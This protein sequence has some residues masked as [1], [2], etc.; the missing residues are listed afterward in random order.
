MI[1][2]P[3]DSHVTY[4]TDGTPVYDRAV[5]SAPL[6]KL[7]KN[8][9]SDGVLPN[10]S[11]N[12]Q[13][14]A[15]TGMNVIVYP[16]FAC[17]NGCM[18]L[19]ESQRTLAVQAS[20]TAYDRID[21]VVLRL[22]DNDSERICDFYILEGTPA[23]SP[24][25]PTLTRSESVWELGLADLFIAK[26]STA[27]S[28]QRI[29]DTRYETARC[30]IMS[31]VSQF[32]T[33]TLYNQIQADLENFQNVSQADFTDWF[34]DIKGQ[35]S[36]DPAGNLQNQIGNLNNLGTA[37]KENI[38]AAVNEV[39]E[40]LN[41]ELDNKQDMVTGAATTVLS[42]N[43]AVNRALAANEIGKIVAVQTTLAELLCLSGVTSNIQNQLNS[44]I[45]VF[46]GTFSGAVNF[47]SGVWNA[48]G[49]DVLFGDQN[50]AGGFCIK[51]A[52]GE[53]S[54]VLQNQ[55]STWYNRI[56]SGNGNDLFLAVNGQ[57]Y[58]S[59]G[60][61][62]AR[63]AIHASAFIQSSSRRLKENIEDMS[64]EEAKK[65]L[66][67]EPVTYDYINEKEGT[68][69]RGLIAEDTAVVIPSCVVGDVNCADDDK[70]ALQ[71]IGI[72]YSKLVPY[73]IKMIQMQQKD[74]ETLKKSLQLLSS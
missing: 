24:V 61:N 12:M 66:L 45:S 33:T 50:I 23:T 28:N 2:F 11:T 73:L 47:A 20:N 16:G 17:C 25:R 29:T 9:F 55:N 70:A 49:D 6:R 7:I 64:E 42:E 32:D 34:E 18:K 59:N 58:V 8:M 13:V 26:N 21:T 72:D 35:L 48:L 67:L 22:N 54:I 14:A 10:P 38:V 56:I 46:G 15:G 4:D 1:G 39:K 51:G 60:S 40:I 53:T 31:S 27:L 71:G 57:V 36:E 62:D 44:K 65:I 30:G 37:T 5:T 41:S 3:L 63:N 52:N 43:L 69:C 19:E 74:I 68:N